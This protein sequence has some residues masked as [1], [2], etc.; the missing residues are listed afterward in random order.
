MKQQE[1]AVGDGVIQNGNEQFIVSFN[2]SGMLFINITGPTWIDAGSNSL[3]LSLVP[4]G[5]TIVDNNSGENQTTETPWSPDVM[6]DV[7]FDCGT[8]VVDPSIDQELDCVRLRILT[9]T[10]STSL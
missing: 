3:E 7:T 4:Y 6:L 5:S 1:I 9:I 2:E 8:V 10:Q